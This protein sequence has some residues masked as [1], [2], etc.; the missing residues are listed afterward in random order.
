[1]RYKVKFN[2]LT[3]IKIFTHK[4]DK[5]TK[6]KLELRREVNSCLASNLLGLHLVILVQE[7]YFQ[8]IQ[9]TSLS[10]NIS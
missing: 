3:N 6:K 9:S 5:Y 2:S 4:M 10:K 1:M 7:Y 8:S